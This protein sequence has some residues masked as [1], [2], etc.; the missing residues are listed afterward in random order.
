MM[1]DRTNKH[2]NEEHG[3]APARAVARAPQLDLHRR[4]GNRVVA[5][6]MRPLAGSGAMSH[7]VPQGSQALSSYEARERDA[8]RAADLAVEHGPAASFSGA[9]LQG[10]RVHHDAHAAA[11]AR[12]QRALAYTVGNDIYFAAGRYQ[13]H[14]REGQRLLFHEIAHVRQQRATGPMVQRK[15]DPKA[16]T[17]SA[18]EIFPYQKGDRVHIASLVPA[19]LLDIMVTGEKLKKLAGK[20]TKEDVEKTKRLRRILNATRQTAVI[21]TVTQSDADTFNAEFATPALEKSGDDP[22]VDSMLVKLSVVRKEGNDFYMSLQWGKEEPTWYLFVPESRE[23]GVAL[24]FQSES[25]ENGKTVRQHEYT[26]LIEPTE[27]GRRKVTV[28]DLPDA[29]KQLL[30][31]QEVPA[32]VTSRI[33]AQKGSAEEKKEVEKTTAWALENS[34]HRGEFELAGGLGFQSGAETDPLLLASWRYL[35]PVSVPGLVVPV[36]LEFAYWP[37]LTRTGEVKAGLELTLPGEATRKI[38][39]FGRLKVPLVVRIVGGARIGSM[40]GAQEEGETGRSRVG[41]FGPTIGGG[42]SVP[43]GPI[44]ITADYAYMYNLLQ[45]AQDKKIDHVHG[46]SLGIKYQF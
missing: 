22:A 15:D 36:G 8:D 13:P 25:E 39:I 7:D 38:P 17:L 31:M 32:V 40:S 34:R 2:R 29:M 6:I 9:D 3:A 26:A 42:L 21:A 43:V 18:S 23:K 1:R 28:T 19:N 10:I 16:G 20:A 24:K 30:S 46:G 37:G 45:D 44:L 5:R 14:T 33:E 27:E 12:V 35:V 4:Y 41:V 11:Q